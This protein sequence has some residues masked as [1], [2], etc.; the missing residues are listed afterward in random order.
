[1]RKLR[2]VENL[3]EAEPRVRELTE[4]HAA[5]PVPE[6]LVTN[7]EVTAAQNTAAG[8]RSDLEGIERKRALRDLAREL[9]MKAQV[10]DRAP[11]PQPSHE[12]R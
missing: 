1:L 2:D 9:E 8:I 5:L 6:R 3:A 11:G 7:D 12:E 4:H 10:N